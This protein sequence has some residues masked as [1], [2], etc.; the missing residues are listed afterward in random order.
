MDALM[1]C[2]RDQPLREFPLTGLP[3]E[4]GSGAGCDIVVH[5]PDV[6]ERHLLVWQ[7]DGAPV[8][9][10]VAGR[11]AAGR[12]RR[13]PV[14]VPVQVGES[15][16]IVRVAGSSV[17]PRKRT[18][19]TE[20][21][22]D[23]NDAS[24][25]LVLLVGRGPG[26]RR[27]VVD[28]MPLTVGSAPGNE[29][30]LADRTVSKRHCRLELHDGGLLVRDLG[31]RN[32]TWVDGVRVFTA[33]VGPGTTIRVGRTDIYVLVRGSRG[34]ARA[35]G[36]V[37]ASSAMLHV[38]AE[39]ERLAR[40]SWPVLI[41]GE[42]GVGKEGVAA[43]L[44]RRGSRRTGPF[45]AINAG[46]LPRHLVESELFGHE[47]G[48]FT[49]AAA[50]RRGV[51]E[52]ADGGTLFLDEIGE[53]PLDVQA[54]LLRVLETWRVRRVGGETDIDVDVRLVCATHRDLRS[55][56]VEGA[57]REDLYYRINHLVVRVPPLRERPDDVRALAA[58]FLEQAASEIGPRQLSEEAVLRLVSH[59][60]PGNARELRNVLRAAA[61]AS[62]SALVDAADV[63]RVLAKMAGPGMVKTV[64]DDT[65]K[66]TLAT[67]RG[68]L[69]A[70][71]RML[72]MPRSTLRD[73]VKA[74]AKTGS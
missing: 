11:R 51:F 52:Q 20:E 23:P 37:A 8:F 15:H 10:E 25:S 73:R 38:L 9:Y 1:L 3:I 4:V 29:L 14:G 16:S 62:A 2:Y 6:A 12:P 72:G 69:S 60:W 40:L 66:Q 63:E 59:S 46:G 44:H 45:V 39:V 26:A 21:L 47:K 27:M 43:A 55:M 17:R 54:R 34:D 19:W 57:F 32:G 42:S 5:D 49:G 31:S 64:G 36:L 56:V 28:G 53:L 74:L 33:R 71:A 18:P 35:E 61:V 30:V 65:L 68:N 24:G 13:L 50:E 22:S 41:Q 67:C 48:A 70:A 7:K 58:H